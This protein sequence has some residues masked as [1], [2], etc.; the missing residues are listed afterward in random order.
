VPSLRVGVQSRPFH[1]LHGVVEAIVRK[2][3][4]IENRND[5]GM[6]QLGHYTSFVQQVVGGGY[7]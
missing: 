4:R 1:Q 2:P 6:F 3:A 7:R 5:A